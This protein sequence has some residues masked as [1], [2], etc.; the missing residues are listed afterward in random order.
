MSRNNFFGVPLKH[1]LEAATGLLLLSPKVMVSG[2]T[3]CKAQMVLVQGFI[4]GLNLRS[5]L[6]I[7]RLVNTAVDQRI[8]K[9]KLNCL[10]AKSQ[11]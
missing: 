3:N 6:S 9:L 1:S 11:T 7:A 8:N 4:I 10:G 5:F 2:K